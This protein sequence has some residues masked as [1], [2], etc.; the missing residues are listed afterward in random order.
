MP[1]YRIHFPFQKVAYTLHCREP[2][3]IAKIKQII[4]GRGRGPGKMQLHFSRPLLMQAR[5][6]QISGLRLEIKAVVQ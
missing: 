3:L 2:K 1:C 4:C 5:M 6:S